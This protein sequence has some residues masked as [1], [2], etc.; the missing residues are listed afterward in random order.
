MPVMDD[1]QFFSFWGS[2]TEQG[3][4]ECLNLDCLTGT[5]HAAHAGRFVWA[6]GLSLELPMDLP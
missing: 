1:P 4:Q 6:D 5:G 3:A 2:K